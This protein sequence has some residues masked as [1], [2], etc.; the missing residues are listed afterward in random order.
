MA[1]H[2]LFVVNMYKYGDHNNH[3]YLLGVFTKKQMAVDTAVK[4]EDDRGDKYSAEIVE[5]APDETIDYIHGEVKYIK[6]AQKPLWY[7]PL[8]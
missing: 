5:V 8:D 1:K 4:E 2:K 7:N 3:S 6:K